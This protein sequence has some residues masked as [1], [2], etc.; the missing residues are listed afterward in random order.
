[1]STCNILN[2]VVGASRPAQHKWKLAMQS[3]WGICIMS[4]NASI[5]LDPPTL[6]PITHLPI[7]TGQYTLPLSPQAADDAIRLINTSKPYFTETQPTDDCTAGRWR[8]C[9]QCLSEHTAPPGS[10]CGKR[11]S[12]R[13]KFKDRSFY[14]VACARL[15]VDLSP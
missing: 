14:V 15:Q 11:F 9:W 4:L 3:L 8:R 12:P 5:S 7:Q 6:F 13:V 1:M 2:I 10:D